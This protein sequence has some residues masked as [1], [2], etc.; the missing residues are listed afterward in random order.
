MRNSA[1]SAIALFIASTWSLPVAAQTD[2]NGTNF[3]HMGDWSWG[4]MM[5]G[6]GLM[7]LLFWVAI[8]VLVVAAV[9]WFRRPSGRTLAPRDASAREVLDERFA[10]GEIDEAEF[11]RRKNALEAGERKQK[12]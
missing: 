12:G 11:Q 4:H 5:Y 3:W 7:M 9:F 1:I 6:G 8:I 2:G 10:R